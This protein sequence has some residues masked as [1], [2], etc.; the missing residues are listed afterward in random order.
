MLTG[1]CD[2]VKLFHFPHQRRHRS[3]H[4]A[5]RLIKV[6]SCN[7]HV[8]NRLSNKRHRHI[9]LTRTLIDHPTLLLLSRPAT[10]LSTRDA[11]SFC[12][13][14]GDLGQRHNLDV[15]VIDRSLRRVP[16]L[17]SAVCYLSRRGV[18]HLSTGRVHA[19]I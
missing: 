7:Y 12:A 2:H 1:L 4:H 5:L 8:L 13:L 3:I 18:A 14:L 15:L 10:K 9:R 11:T 6:R 19:C 17:A 16:Q